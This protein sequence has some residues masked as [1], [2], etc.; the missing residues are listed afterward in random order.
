MVRTWLQVRPEWE[1]VGD[2][3]EQGDL[4]WF[5]EDGTCQAKELP[6]ELASRPVR[7]GLEGGDSAGREVLGSVS[8]CNPGQRECKS[9]P[10]KVRWKLEEGTGIGENRKDNFCGDWATNS[11]R[12]K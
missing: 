4:S 2:L 8:S 9:E 11:H 7:V 12:S 6:G 5:M 1:R 3:A 10:G